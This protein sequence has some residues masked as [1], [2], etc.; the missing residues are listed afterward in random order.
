MKITFIRHSKVLFTWK[1]FYNSNTFDLACLEYDSSSIGSPQKMNFPEQT[2]LISNQQR[3]ADTACSVVGE[4]EIIK[5][6]LLNEI[7]LRSFIDTKIKLPVFFWMIAGRLQWYFN[8]SRQIES[9]TKSKE[10]ISQFID[11]LEQKQHDCLI[12]GHGFYFAQFVPEM[13]NRGFTGDM[14][15]RIRNEELRE[16]SK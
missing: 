12:I 14:R 6:N 10:R 8:N 2:L 5:T 1:P 9:R 11:Y 13:K 3:S 16:F 4:K 15:K 7:P